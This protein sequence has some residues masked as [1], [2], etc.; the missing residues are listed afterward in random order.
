MNADQKIEHNKIVLED[1]KK[2]QHIIYDEVINLDINNQNI[3]DIVNSCNRNMNEKKSMTYILNQIQQLYQ[4]VSHQLDILT[5]N[6]SHNVQLY[7]FVS[8]PSYSYTIDQNGITSAIGTSKQSTYSILST[9]TLM[10]WLL[11]LLDLL[12]ILL[13]KNLRHLIRYLYYKLR[14]YVRNLTYTKFS[15]ILSYILNEININPLE[16][17]L[18]IFGQ[19]EERIHGPIE[20]VCKNTFKMDA[21]INIDFGITLPIYNK[22]DITCNIKLDKSQQIE[23]FLIIEHF[24][25]MNEFVTYCRKKNITKF[26]I[27]SPHGVPK[28]NIRVWL[29]H[30]QNQH[31]TIPKLY[32]YDH[33]PYG[34]IAHRIVAFGKIGHFN[35]NKYTAVPQVIPFGINSIYEHHWQKI[36]PR[37]INKDA[38]KSANTFNDHFIKHHHPQKIYY[39]NLIQLYL[40]ND[41]SHSLFDFE[42]SYII[43]LIDKFITYAK[44]YDIKFESQP[45]NPPTIDYIHKI[46]TIDFF[47]AKNFKWHFKWDKSTELPNQ[48]INKLIYIINKNYTNTLNMLTIQLNVEAIVPRYILKNEGKFD[49]QIC[50]V[51][52]TGRYNVIL[53]DNSTTEIYI[54]YIFHGSKG[55]KMELRNDEQYDIITYCYKRYNIKKNKSV[56]T[57]MNWTPIKVEKLSKKD[58]IK[59]SGV[60]AFFFTIDLISCNF[61]FDNIFTKCNYSA[62][63]VNIAMYNIMLILS[64]EELHKFNNELKNKPGKDTM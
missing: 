4:D 57:M 17:Q 7:C 47:D 54:F 55:G 12:K 20:F 6:K 8:A 3:N 23:A 2:I 33:D 46:T 62:N 35:L 14:N 1:L 11:I 58:I 24:A 16:I 48:I 28:L 30:L 43:E 42:P 5:T 21:E 9:S 10:I 32:L 26:I 27:I 34:M 45:S 63:N 37:A 52:K 39:R 60:W 49:L 36:L 64:K 19:N 41:I 51:A 31:P 15:A 18:P 22:D 13:R 38:L 50:Q 56:R 25:F 29:K 61:D 59:F 53:Y 40:Q 44:E